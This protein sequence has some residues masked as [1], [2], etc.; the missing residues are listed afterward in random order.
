M[1]NKLQTVAIVC[2]GWYWEVLKERRDNLK[3]LSDS[4]GVP[5]QWMF[6]TEPSLHCG[7][8]ALYQITSTRFIAKCPHYPT[9]P[10]Y[11][12]WNKCCHIYRWR[13]ANRGA[14]CAPA[15]G[16][17]SRIVIINPT[18]GWWILV[19]HISK[20]I[21]LQSWVKCDVVYTCDV[22]SIWTRLLMDIMVYC[23]IFYR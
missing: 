21:A 4:V 17:N 18:I 15:S 12:S 6:L 16:C 19:I 11:K 23:V 22:G 10:P 5:L 2:R 3:A 20:F 1:I 8:S 14:F 13:I 7:P 9:L